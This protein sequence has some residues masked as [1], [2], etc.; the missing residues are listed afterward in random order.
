VER[1]G[2]VSRLKVAQGALWAAPDL[3]RLSHASA[4]TLAG[5]VFR[6]LREHHPAFRRTSETIE[7]RRGKLIAHENLLLARVG[8]LSLK[9]MLEKKFG[10]PGQLVSLSREFVAFPN[11]LL[12]EIKSWLKKSG[13]VVKSLNSGEASAEDS[14]I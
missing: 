10:A 11:G 1:V 8:D 12:P 4:G 9:M 14:E 7:Q 6:W 2:E 3:V 5:P 13:H